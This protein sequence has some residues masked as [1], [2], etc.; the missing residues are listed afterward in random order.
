MDVCDYGVVHGVRPGNM[1]LCDV[2]QDALLAAG[3]QSCISADQRK[4]G[5]HMPVCIVD[6]VGVHHFSSCGLLL[7]VLFVL[8]C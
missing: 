7:L 3:M 5:S 6:F 4:P 2:M 1:Q 8:R